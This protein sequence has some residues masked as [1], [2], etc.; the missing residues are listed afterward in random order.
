M[1]S[2]RLPSVAVVSQLFAAIDGQMTAR[3]L[4]ERRLSGGRVGRPEGLQRSSPAYGLVAVGATML[5]E[6]S[7]TYENCLSGRESTLGREG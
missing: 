3:D 6:R 4:L 1:D 2:K 5:S 7:L